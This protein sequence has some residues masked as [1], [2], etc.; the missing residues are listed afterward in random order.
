MTRRDYGQH[1]G[2]ARALE[3]LGERWTILIVREL[4]TGPKRFTDLAERLPRMGRNLLAER[5]R[6]LQADTV[7]ERSGRRYELTPLG[8][9]LL[10]ALE[11][12][13]VWG[14]QLL[15]PYPS[16]RTVNAAWSTLTMRAG[17]DNDACRDVRATI[18][19]RID[20]Q[21]LLIELDHGEVRILES[22]PSSPPDLTAT[23]GEETYLAL[24]YGA[25]RVEDALTA[26]LLHHEGER[27]LLDVCFQVLR[28]PPY[29]AMDTPS[30]HRE[31]F[32]DQ[33]GRA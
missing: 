12:L 1:C 31:L 7:I 14:M 9:E 22:D 24:G 25:L 33:F 21:P 23:C 17:G 19:L 28:F 11:H 27:R 29:P 15:A 5:L 13:A 20:G 6:Q 3:V 32:D 26:G 2:L 16:G 18:A 10:P 30:D 4:L 8:H